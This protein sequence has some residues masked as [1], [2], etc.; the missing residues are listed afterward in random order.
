LLSVDVK[1]LGQPNKGEGMTGTNE[2]RFNIEAD[3]P[4][5]EQIEARKLYNN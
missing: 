1:G 4:T 5:A 2:K 3:P